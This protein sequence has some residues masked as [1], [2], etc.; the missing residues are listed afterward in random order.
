[1]YGFTRARFA[2]FAAAAVLASVLNATTSY[3]Q[4][5]TVFEGGRLIVGDGRV[6]ENGVL[7]VEGN[8]ITYAGAAAGAKVP[9]GAAR[10]NVAGKTLM[11]AL[12]DTHVHTGQDTAALTRDLKQRAYWGVGASMS[13]GQDTGEAP[14]QLRA[15]TPPG[16]ARTFTAG[17]GITMP[18]PGRTTAPIWIKDEAEGRKA[19]RD[20]AAK[21]VDIV[22]VWVDD[23]D[24][25]VSKM[26]PALYGAIID[27][28][29]KA[30]VRVTAHIFNLEDAKGLLRAGL[31]AFAHGVRDKDIDAEFT[32]MLKT[33]P[34]LVLNP[35]MAPRG[36]VADIA[37][38]KASLPAEEYA[39]LEKGNI[40][41]A[42]AQAFHGIQARN[43]AKMNAAGVKI[44]LGTD[45]N[46]PYAPHFEMEDM[47]LAGMTP[48]Q[49]ITASTKNGA[50]FLKIADMGTLEAGKSADFIVLDANPL[51]AIT[52]T[53]KISRVYLRGAAIDRS[54]LP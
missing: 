38:L 54:K 2:G 35:N 46:T 19:V 1:M 29:H 9:A 12:V 10:E 43:L 22:K 6:V 18:E 49:V 52:N 23:R 45:G 7:V 50:E 16:A 27:E 3:A 25:T 53:R 47:V 40:N 41:D 39:R 44:V 28:A 26:P 4:S 11:P 8:R 36:A 20:N 5:A 33:Y 14:F 31:D 30:G 13:M 24:A 37:W 32:A 51:E 21:K 48:A 42:K 15:A 17:R 34:N